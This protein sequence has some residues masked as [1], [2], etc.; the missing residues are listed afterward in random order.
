MRTIRV[1][2]KDDNGEPVDLSTGVPLERVEDDRHFADS[3]AFTVACGLLYCSDWIPG[4]L[5]DPVITV[6]DRE[7]DVDFFLDE[8]GRI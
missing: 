8:K 1:Q 5:H 7:I 4:S 3:L 2:A 6:D